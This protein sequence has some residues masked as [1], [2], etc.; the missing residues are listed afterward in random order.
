MGNR[1]DLG[2]GLLLPHAIPRSKAEGIKCLLLFLFEAAF[3]VQPSLRKIVFRIGEV[4][5]DGPGSI[6]G[7]GDRNVCWDRD[8]GDYRRLRGYS[9]HGE[10][11]WRADSE[12]FFQTGIQVGKLGNRG[13]V[14]IFLLLERGANLVHSL[15]KLGGVLSKLGDRPGQMRR[16]TFTSSDQEHDCIDGDLVAG[17]GP[18]FH[19]CFGHVRDEVRT[20]C[21]RIQPLR[22]R[23]LDEDRKVLSSLPETGRN[24]SDG[25]PEKTESIQGAR[26]NASFQRVQGEAGALVIF[27]IFEVPNRLAEGKIGNDIEGHEVKPIYKVNKPVALAELAHQRVDVRLDHRLL[28]FERLGGKCIGKLSP[29]PTVLLV[30]CEEKGSNPLFGRRRE[31]VPVSRQLL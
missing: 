27:P 29:E 21:L 15:R 4:I 16:S 24:E 12:T 17:H 3:L 8:S 30:V 1:T 9:A 20:I 18:V 5:L 6:L 10:R 31:E 22:D 19:L 25:E 28:L 7:D 2:G 26:E 23:I 14:D 11:R 13:D